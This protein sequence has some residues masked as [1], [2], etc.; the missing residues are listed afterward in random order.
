MKLLFPQKNQAKRR[1]QELLPRLLNLLRN[2]PLRKKGK[3]FPKLAT[4]FGTL[5]EA[6]VCK[7]VTI[8]PHLHGRLF[9]VRFFDKNGSGKVAIT[10]RRF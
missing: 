6:T 8:K 10:Q 7:P 1:K 3:F 2:I 4:F 9:C 5:L